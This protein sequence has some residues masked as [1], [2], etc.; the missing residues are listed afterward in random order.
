MAYDSGTHLLILYD[1]TGTITGVGQ[2]NQEE[3][4]RQGRKG[5]R[6]NCFKRSLA[7]FVPLGVTREEQA[8]RTLLTA[9]R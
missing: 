5:L 6:S 7:H 2:M 1:D 4:E 3:V 9:L 8:R